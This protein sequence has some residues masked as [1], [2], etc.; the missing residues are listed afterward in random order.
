MDMM[1]MNLAAVLAQELDEIKPTRILHHWKRCPPGPTPTEECWQIAAGE[2]KSL[3]FRVW[4][5]IDFPCSK[6]IDPHTWVTP[7]G[8][9][10]LIKR[11]RRRGGGGGTYGK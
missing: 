3:I 6:W 5:F 8:F 4:P 11:N 9:R 7:M 2:G 1:L 10:A